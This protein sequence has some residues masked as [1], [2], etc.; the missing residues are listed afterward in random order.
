MKQPALRRLALA[1]LA[2]C[3]LAGTAQAQPGRPQ[4]PAFREGTQAFRHLL[5]TLGLQPLTAPEQLGE[6][7]ERKLLILL[8]ETDVLGTWDLD[9]DAFVRRGGAVLIA[10]DRPTHP[11]I[12]LAF[13][14]RVSGGRVMTQP[15]GKLAYRESPECPILIPTLLGNKLLFK[16]LRAVATNRPSTLDQVSQARSRGLVPLA[17]FPISSWV[18]GQVLPGRILNLF[19]VGG[20]REDGRVLL[21]ADHSVFINDML[22][23]PDNDNALFAFQCIRWLTGEGQ[24]T[25]VLFVEEGLTQTSFDV[26]LEDP[27]LGPLPPLDVFVPVVNRAVK[28]LEDE[29]IFTRIFENHLNQV[30]PLR[31][32]QSVVLLATLAMICYGFLRLGQARHRTE[33]GAPLLATALVR[34]VPVGAALEQRQQALLHAGNVW[35]AARAVARQRFEAALGP[36]GTEAAL[37]WASATLVP[38]PL[39]V[40]GSWWR[41]WVARRR[42]ERL[43]RLAFG[44]TPVRVTPRQLARVRA[45]MDQIQ[46]ALA[47]GSLRIDLPEPAGGRGNGVASG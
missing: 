29:G 45:E 10:T 7:P 20:D 2:A 8:G 3:L 31:F 42:V 28:G 47:N 40:R 34:A 11:A 19:A 4:R 23:R 1:C 36:R 33:P 41:R 46:A 43:W 27:G 39:A 26:P 35:E 30:T 16:G 32:L 6:A 38:P 12:A 18:E 14:Y 22:L 37:A 21:L 24:R 5:K 25:E 17:G 13:G 9:L 44:D 15:E